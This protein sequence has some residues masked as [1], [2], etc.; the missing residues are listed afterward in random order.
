VL[1]TYPD[2]GRPIYAKGLCGTHR[3]YVLR[4]QP[5]K[6]IPFKANPGEGYTAKKGYRTIRVNKTHRVSEHRYIM[7]QHLGRPLDAKETVHHKNG[8]RSDNRIENLELWVGRHRHGQ[9]VEDRVQDAI[10]TLRRSAP[11]KLA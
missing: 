5:L 8:I 2:C 11:D 1:C 6:P 7:A 3:K 4:G 9:R 10:D